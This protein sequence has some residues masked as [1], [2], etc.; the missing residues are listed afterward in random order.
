MPGW[1]VLEKVSLPLTEAVQRALRIQAALLPNNRRL[2]ASFF[3][4]DPLKH[5]AALSNSFQKRK[6][7]RIRYFS[8]CCDRSNLWHGFLVAH[9]LRE[10]FHRREGVLVRAWDSWEHCFCSQDAEGECWSS[11]GFSHLPFKFCL[12]PC[13]PIQGGFPS[14]GKPFGNVFTDT[15]RNVSP[16]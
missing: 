4:W 9:S 16:R 15:L 1:G 10:T 14:S 11:A 12:D 6:S 7:Y 5:K 8:C 2:T 3:S 13:C